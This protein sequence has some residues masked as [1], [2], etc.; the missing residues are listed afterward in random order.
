MC[1]VNMPHDLIFCD[2]CDNV[3]FIQTDSDGAHFV[4]PCCNTRVEMFTDN[5]SRCISRRS[6]VGESIQT[7][8][9]NPHVLEDPTLPCTTMINCPNKECTRGDQPNQV[10]YMNYNNKEL[11]FLYSCLHCKHNWTIEH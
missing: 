9:I 11:R 6:L 10:V 7:S 3:L 2:K 1:N 4:C 5:S 8:T